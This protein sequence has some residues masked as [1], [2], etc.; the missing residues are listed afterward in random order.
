MKL[1][2]FCNNRSLDEHSCLQVDTIGAPIRRVVAEVFAIDLIHLCDVAYD[3]LQ[4]ETDRDDCG[5]ID[6]GLPK[7]F[8]ILTKNFAHLGTGTARYRSVATWW[9]TSENRLHRAAVV[10]DS[11]AER[12]GWAGTKEFVQLSEH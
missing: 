9:N 6:T 2:E 12:K 1:G 11:S 8:V 4:I 5:A 3:L 7:K 10:D